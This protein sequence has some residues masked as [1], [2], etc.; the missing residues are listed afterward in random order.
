M[1]RTITFSSKIAILLLYFSLVMSAH[2]Q[3]WQIE[4]SSGQT[5]ISSRQLVE[6]S[7]KQAEKEVKATTVVKASSASLLALL[8]DTAN[9]PEWIDNCLEVKVLAGATSNTKIVRSTFA[10]PW[11][12]QNRD[13]VIQSVTKVNADSIFIEVTDAGQLYPEQNNTVRMTHIRGLWTVTQLSQELV[14]ITYQGSGNAS[15]KV[16]TWLANKVLVDST[17]S[18]FLRLNKIITEQSYQRGLITP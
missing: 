3:E 8:D 18:T 11:P 12:L 1:Q 6:N 16:P 4:K 15:G 14:R 5:Q 7:E 9:A 10:A 17:F 2:S 13:M